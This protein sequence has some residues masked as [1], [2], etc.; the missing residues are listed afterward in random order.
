MT[1]SQ[2]K[3]ASDTPEK[4]LAAS[5]RLYC[6]DQKHIRHGFQGVGTKRSF[7]RLDLAWAENLWRYTDFTASDK[8]ST[9]V[10]AVPTFRVDDCLVD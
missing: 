10:P 5:R 8:V 6:S 9:Q 1:V 7:S 2:S 3:D 4:I